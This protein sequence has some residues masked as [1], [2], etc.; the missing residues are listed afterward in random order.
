M[1]QL[2]PYLRPTIEQV[3][4]SPYFEKVRSFS[5]D[6]CAKH[7]VNLD[8]ETRDMTVQEMR[9][10]FTKIVNDYMQSTSNQSADL[11]MQQ[12]QQRNR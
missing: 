10:E 5:D 3:L 8:I 9:H 12:Q 1:L 6:R 7:Q 2:N 4:T 11:L